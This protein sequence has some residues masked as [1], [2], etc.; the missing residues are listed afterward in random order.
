MMGILWLDHVPV[1]GLTINL[2]CL[3]NIMLLNIWVLVLI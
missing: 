3:I 1:L 2:K